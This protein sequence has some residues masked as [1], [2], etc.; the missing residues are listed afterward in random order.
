MTDRQLQKLAVLM[1]LMFLPPALFKLS[2]FFLA[3]QFFTKWGIPSWM[4]H[5]I[6]ASELAGAIGLLVPRT[7]PAAAFALSL[8]MIGGLVT[9]LA[10]SEYV[11]AAMPIIYGAGLYLLMRDSLP[12]FSMRQTARAT[13]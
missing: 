6:G 8:L 10:H 2:N 7:R 13:V 11:F 3:V 12:R 4:M 5:F 1:S 9:H